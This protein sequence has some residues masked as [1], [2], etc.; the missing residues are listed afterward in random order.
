MADQEKGAPP[1]EETERVK[2]PYDDP[3][4]FSIRYKWMMTLLLAGTT[5]TVTFGSSIWSS[6]IEKTADEFHT[7]RTVSLLGVSLY[8]L[9]FSLGP[10][11]WGPLSEMYGRK[12]P[13]FVGYAVFALMQIPVALGYNMPGILVCRL[14]AGCFG[15]APVV[16]V[17]AS[18]ADFWDPGRRGNAAAA[19]SVASFAGPTLGPVIGT[20]VTESHLGWRWTAWITLIMAG[21][22][23]PLAFMFVPETYAPVLKKQNPKYTF[24][25]FVRK[26]FFKPMLMLGSEL[27]LVVLTLYVSIVYGI[28]YLTFYAIPYIYQ[29]DKHWSVRSASLPFLSMLVGILLSCILVALHSSYYYQPRLK[30]R[31]GKVVPEDR[32]PLIMLGS[33]LLPAG[34]FWFAW[35]K[36]W[37]AIAFI[38]AGIMLIFTTS[39]AFIID[40][41][42]ASSASAMAANCIV[43]SAAAAG[44]PLAAPKM[45][46]SLGSEW[47]TSLLGFLC[48]A[49]I[50]APFVFHK[51]GEKLRKRSKFTPTP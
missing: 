47:A 25:D 11:L 41:Y 5:F 15:A 50:P 1:T 4:D 3:Y 42:R 26:F 29:H 10:T 20:F 13:L 48:V 23:G 18:Y 31:G 39:V 35:T 49:L 22:F 30:K 19:Y 12:K 32:L 33:L 51:Y 2:P 34:L 46:Q 6:T 44:L 8:V 24:D 9:G 16:I 21:V 14:L 28:M 40:V 37:E 43:R 36:Q 7:T 27:M 17:S 38:G 45:Y